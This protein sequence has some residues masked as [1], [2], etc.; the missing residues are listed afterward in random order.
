LIRRSIVPLI[1]PLIVSLGPS[2]TVSFL[3]MDY[4][5]GLTNINNKTPGTA[6][7]RSGLVELCAAAKSQSYRNPLIF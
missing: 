6:S 5:A 2:V 3:W 7:G 1:I 4:A